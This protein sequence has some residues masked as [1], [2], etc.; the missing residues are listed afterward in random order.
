MKTVDY[1]AIFH[2]RVCRAKSEVKHLSDLLE[3]MDEAC[4]QNEDGTYNFDAIDTESLEL[5]GILSDAI[6]RECSS[7]KN[8]LAWHRREK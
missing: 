5:L 4:Q 8:A 3:K 1:P 2:L 6:E 7:A